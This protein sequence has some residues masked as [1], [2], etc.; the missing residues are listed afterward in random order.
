MKRAALLAGLAL[1]A[2]AAPATA[3]LVPLARC[4][5]AYPCNVP[6]G[7]RPADAA[8]NLPDA[9]LGN[10]LVSVGVDNAFK[11]KL[12]AS[13]IS[14]DPVEGAARLYLRKNPIVLRT[15]TPKPAAK[16]DASKPDGAKPDA[17]K[18]G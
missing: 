9:Q 18:P 16:P 12:I 13:P 8:A 4:H 10:A 2:L 17:S 15:P 1:A 6:Y 14:D 11:P 7:L 3:Q 5:A